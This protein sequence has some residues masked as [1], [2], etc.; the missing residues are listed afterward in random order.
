M[1]QYD[2]SVGPGYIIG[3]QRVAGKLKAIGTTATLSDLS[4]TDISNTGATASLATNQRH[5]LRAVSS[6]GSSAILPYTFTTTGVKS[7]SVTLTNTKTLS[8]QSVSDTVSVIEGI[9]KAEIDISVYLEKGVDAVFK[10]KPHT[11]NF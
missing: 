3:Y 11:G 10:L 8:S 6:T 5:L 7:I 4:T 9:D 1:T 2:V